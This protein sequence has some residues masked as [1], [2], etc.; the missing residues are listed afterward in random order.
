MSL[1]L[2]LWCVTFRL[3]RRFW[4]WLSP[5]PVC[6]A[7]V[8]AL[9]GRILPKLSKPRSIRD[10]DPEIRSKRSNESMRALCWTAQRDQSSV[11]SAPLAKCQKRMRIPSLSRSSSCKEM[12]RKDIAVCCR[13]PER[14]S[15]KSENSIASFL[16]ANFDSNS[17]RR[18]NALSRFQTKGPSLPPPSASATVG[19]CLLQCSIPP[20]MPVCCQMSRRVRRPSAIER[21]PCGLRHARRTYFVLPCFSTRSRSFPFLESFKSSSQYDSICLNVSI[22]CVSASVE[23]QPCFLTSCQETCQKTYKSLACS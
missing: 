7:P 22:H 4:R 15:E 12:V 9:C 19:S 20:L 23:S 18:K 21:E 5:L 13:L 8:V 16:A 14:E 10:R 11:A 3:D 1:D 2:G 6:F 17:N